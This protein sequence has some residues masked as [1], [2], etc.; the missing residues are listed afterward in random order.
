MSLINLLKTDIFSTGNRNSRLIRTAFKQVFLDRRSE[1]NDYLML[2]AC[3]V[4]CT[5]VFDSF[6]RN[7]LT[8]ADPDADADAAGQL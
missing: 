3:S 8:P 4:S 1:T 2:T 5:T 6:S 7:Q